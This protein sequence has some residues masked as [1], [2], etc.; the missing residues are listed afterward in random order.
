MGPAHR[1]MKPQTMTPKVKSIATV[2]AV[3]L[4]DAFAATSQNVCV[5]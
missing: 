5:V 3:S 1:Q 2:L 4:V